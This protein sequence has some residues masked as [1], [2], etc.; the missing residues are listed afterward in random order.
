MVCWAWAHGP[1]GEEEPARR[2]STTPPPLD[3]GL[4]LPARSLS[5]CILDQRGAVLVH[6]QM[7]TDPEAFL[8]TVAPSRAGLVVAVACRCPW[9]W[10]ADWGAEAGRPWG[11][12]PARS[13]QALPGGQAPNDP[14]DAQKM[15]ALLPGGMLPQADGSPAH[16]RATR[17]LRRRR[18]PLTP[19]RAA[20]LAPV[21]NTTSQSP[22][23]ALGPKIAAKANRAGG[24]ARC[25]APAV[26]PRLAV[27]L[28]LIPSDD[29]LLRDVARPIVT[30]ARHQDAHPRSLRPTVPGIGPLL[31]RVLPDASQAITRGPRGQECLSSGRLGP[32][33]QA[34]AG[35]RVGP[36]GAQRAKAH[37]TWALAEAAVVFRRAHAAA[38]TDLARLAQRQDQGQA[39]PILAP[40]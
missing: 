36:S 32:C 16:M 4:D 30:T 8:Q 38:H 9:D 10:L 29:A 25:A 13:L 22:L 40:P 21:P 3:C 37:R 35:Q 28:A 14:S 6:R 11:L 5:V 27:A 23:P 12:G 18:R 17:A 33:A 1:Y 26:P 34:S 15:A 39:L 20:L 19:K 31:R 7:H 24:A 2:F